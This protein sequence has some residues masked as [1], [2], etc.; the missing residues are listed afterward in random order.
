VLPISFS[1]HSPYANE[2]RAD[3]ATTDNDRELRSQPC[4]S[5]NDRQK[6]MTSVVLPETF[7]KVTDEE[8]REFEAE[9]KKEISPGHPLAGIAAV[10]V[11]RSSRRDDFLFHL[12][13]HAEQF[14]IVHLTWS[15]ETVPD[16][17]WTTFF[18]SEE[19]FV[20]NW[21]RIFD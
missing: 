20:Q 18:K 8:A 4:L 2:T 10:C 21:R 7:V 3:P 16:Y 12:P 1:K 11:A 15:K 17:P 19:D 5:S 9:L 6:K 14:A 13:S